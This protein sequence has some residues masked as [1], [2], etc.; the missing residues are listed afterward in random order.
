MFETETSEVRHVF[1]T[2]NGRDETRRGMR[3]VRVMKDDAKANITRQ[4]VCARPTSVHAGLQRSYGGDEAASHP[5]SASKE[6]QFT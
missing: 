1:A 6:S 3:V 5:G 2:M 4:L